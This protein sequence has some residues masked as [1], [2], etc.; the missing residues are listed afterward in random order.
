MIE[1]V[2]KYPYSIYE[3]YFPNGNEEEFNQAFV[4]FDYDESK[5]NESWEA[6]EC[7]E[8]Y[9]CIE[10]VIFD[11]RKINTDCIFGNILNK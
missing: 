7:D 10:G 9:I 1:E 3:K 6:L 11:K 4:T 8:N 5:I 2:Y